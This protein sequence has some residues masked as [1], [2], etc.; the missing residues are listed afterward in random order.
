MSKSLTF[1]EKISKSDTN[2]NILIPNLYHLN[3]ILT[4]IDFF[5]ETWD[6]EASLRS[7]GNE[8]FKMTPTYFKHH[9]SIDLSKFVY[10]IEE[11]NT[12]D[13]LIKP[14]Q[15]KKDFILTIR[16][17]YNPSIGCLYYQ[18]TIRYSEFD[19]PD[20]NKIITNN[21]VTEICQRGNRPSV[22][23]IN[24]DVVIE[25]IKLMPKFKSS[26]LD[27]E[28]YHFEVTPNEMKYKIDFT[29]EDFPKPLYKLLPFYT[30]QI[31]LL[32]DDTS[33]SNMDVPI[34]FLAYGLKSEIN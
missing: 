8:I 31:Q 21:L 15:L 19:Q 29:S 5:S 17:T 13:I 28:Y 2:N 27:D 7:N 32:T 34:H 9:Q 16:Y 4:K 12:M 10:K 11:S 25:K 20:G 22:L 18:N 30:F 3:V 1:S 6:F 26:D 23:E 33:N 14:K 24:S